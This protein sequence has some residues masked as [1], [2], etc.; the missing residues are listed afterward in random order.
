MTGH[1]LAGSARGFTMTE[2][3]VVVAIIGVIM[4]VSAPAMWTYF[5]AAAMRAGAEELVTA[6]NSARELAIRSNTTV[7]V[8]ND[9]VRLQ[10][11]LGNCNTGTIWTG[12]GTDA[13]GWVT[14]ANNLQVNSTPP[15][16]CYNYLGAG[17]PT[18]AN[19]FSQAAFTITNPAGGQTMTVQVAATGRA[20]IQ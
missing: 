12:P 9:N 5:R 20:R 18:P 15:T 19:C 2:I 3:L 7:C 1:R 6:L 17:V 10:Y 16:L 14:L 8:T 13:Q 4:A 11:R